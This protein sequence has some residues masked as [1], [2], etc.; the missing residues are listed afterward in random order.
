MKIAIGCA[1]LIIQITVPNSAVLTQPEQELGKVV[2]IQRVKPLPTKLPVPI[3][4][5]N[6]LEGTAGLLYQREQC[7]KESQVG[8]KGALN[9]DVFLLRLEVAN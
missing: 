1:R 4:Q 8:Q 2:N 6:Y 5:Q 9:W 3:D 7:K